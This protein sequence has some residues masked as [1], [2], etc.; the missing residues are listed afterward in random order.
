MR[1][2]KLH[3]N[4][5]GEGQTVICLH[6]SASSSKQWRALIDKLVSG[7]HVITPD[8]Y[9]YG[10]SPVWNGG[11]KMSLDQEVSLLESLFE[12][13]G[14][15]VHLIGHSFG[16][17]L[18]IKAALKYPNKVK[19]LIVYEPVL[20]WLLFDSHGSAEEEIEIRRIR[21]AVSTLLEERQ[22]HEAARIFV[23]Y[24]NG[25]GSWE[26]LDSRRHSILA[27]S[28][29][30][31][32]MNF[33]SLFSDSI[34]L[35][36]FSKINIPVLYLHGAETKNST[37]R[38]TELLTASLP[39]LEFCVLPGMGHMGPVT[40]AES[41]NGLIFRFLQRLDGMNTHARKV[42]DNTRKSKFPPG[43]G[44]CL[45]H[46]SHASVF[47]ERDSRSKLGSMLCN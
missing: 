41:V 43:M 39:R 36:D 15:P 7:Y 34:A 22:P 26:K 3:T 19:S 30:S 31:V 16:A 40:H 1:N 33:D 8:L 38:I 23:N 29:R 10:K 42:E 14:E 6:S 12:E 18:A 21:D 2:L 28:M 17:A 27:G 44:R 35:S 46:E 32:L 13:Q 45:R 5:Y 11:M 47:A 25:D 4:H 24:W 20:F 37:R 9:G